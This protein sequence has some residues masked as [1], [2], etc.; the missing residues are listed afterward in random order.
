M[1]FHANGAIEYARQLRQR[2]P[3]TADRARCKKSAAYRRRFGPATQ[4][5]EPKSA[6]SYMAKKRK[7]A[8][9]IKLAVSCPYCNQLAELHDSSVVYSRSYG[10]IWICFACK[11]WVGTHKDS[12]E[13]KPLGRLAN[14]ELR[15]AK[16]KAHAVFDP[17]WK[18]KHVKD[19]VPKHEARHAGYSWLASRMEISVNEC[20]IGMFDIHQC[21]RVVEICKPYTEKFSNKVNV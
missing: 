11:A 10:K 3:K 6:S 14:E 12:K 1:S 7:K 19:S 9:A 4:N 13:H 8:K 15:E 5:V 17:L 16:K 2:R 21:Q 20:H 18:R